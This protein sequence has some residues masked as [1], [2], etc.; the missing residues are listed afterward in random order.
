[1]PKMVPVG[2]Q[3]LWHFIIY[4]SLLEKWD[5]VYDHNKASL[6]DSEYFRLDLT[7]N[8]VHALLYKHWER[9]CHHG[10]YT[11]QK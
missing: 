1:M 7:K 2:L 8:L 9:L 5:I 10:R 11:T 4:V 6:V 3:L